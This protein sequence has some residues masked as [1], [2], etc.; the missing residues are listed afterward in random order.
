MSR[1][2]EIIIRRR[3]DGSID[4]EFHAR[5]GAHLRDAAMREMLARWAEWLG[6]TLARLTGMAQARSGKIAL[7]A[8]LH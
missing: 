7:Q 2:D 6:R 4:T 3:P 8:R 1:E 5:H